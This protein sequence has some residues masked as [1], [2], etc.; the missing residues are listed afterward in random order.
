M[1]RKNPNVAALLSMYW[2]NV[3]KNPRGPGPYLCSGMRARAHYGKK[4]NLRM[5]QD[6][7]IKPMVRPTPPPIK[8]PILSINESVPD[9]WQSKTRSYLTI[10]SVSIQRSLCVIYARKEL[11][12]IPYRWFLMARS[13][14]RSRHIRIK[15]PTEVMVYDQVTTPLIILSWLPVCLELSR[16]R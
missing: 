15:I 6:P 5:L 16:L 8:A 7:N 1:E 4:T 2:D 12:F 10:L 11:T 9:P 3:D 14:S 13:R